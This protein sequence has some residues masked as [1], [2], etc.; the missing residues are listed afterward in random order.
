MPTHSA[1]RYHAVLADPDDPEVQANWAR[2][3]EASAGTTPF[4]AL[5]YARSAAEAF[6]LRLRLGVAFRD[7]R[8]VAGLPL[9]VRPRPHELIVPPLTP[10]TPILPGTGWPASEIHR[11]TS[12]LD[13]LLEVVEGEYPAATLHLQPALSD[14]RAFDW[15]GW[16]VRPL[17]TYFVELSPKAPPPS[18]WSKNDRRL[19]LQQREN[20]SL[21]ESKDALET[22]LA[23]CAASYRRH[24]RRFPAPE[25]RVRRLAARLQEAELLRAFTLTPPEASEPEAGVLLLQDAGAA[26]YWMAGSRPGPAATLLLGHLLTRLCDEGVDRLDFV[27][28]N[29]PSIAEFKRKFGSELAPYY[30]VHRAVGLLARLRDLIRRLR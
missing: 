19:F 13:A 16:T 14:T 6:G 29:T 10:Y 27:G 26:C 8:P 22:V 21:I 25:N 3:R 24:G 4:D 20:S 5:A 11:H 23:L 18:G 9:Y 7:D 17:Y 15:R 28:A 30:R 12:A 2:L 1:T